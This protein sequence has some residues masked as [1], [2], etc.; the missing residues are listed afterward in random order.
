MD[1]EKLITSV[2][3]IE[4]LAKAVRSGNGCIPITKLTGGDARIPD[5]CFGSLVIDRDDF[6]LRVRSYPLPDQIG[7]MESLMREK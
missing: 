7:V 4:E 1:R 3:S 5:P 6:E 2:S